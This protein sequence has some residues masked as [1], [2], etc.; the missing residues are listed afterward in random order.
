MSAGF[1]VWDGAGRMVLD[2]TSRAGRVVGIVYTG[3]G[4]GSYPAD[5]SGGT[6]FWAFMP[7]WIFRRVGGAEPTPV[8][9]IDAFGISWSYSGNSSGSNAYSPVPG[10]LVFGVY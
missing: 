8:V 1:W 7:Q 10:W 4:A 2:G 6:P 3:G 9:A 5:L